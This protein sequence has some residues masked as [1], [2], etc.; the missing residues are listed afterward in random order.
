MLSLLVTTG[1]DIKLVWV[2]LEAASSDRAKKENV[3]TDKL[4]STTCLCT[5]NQFPA[6]PCPKPRPVFVHLLHV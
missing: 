1:S 3:K 6:L 5:T 2:L 4:F